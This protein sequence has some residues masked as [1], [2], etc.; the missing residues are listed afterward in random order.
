MAKKFEKF[1]FGCFLLWVKVVGGEMCG[2]LCH[3][4]GGWFVWLGFILMWR[5]SDLQKIEPLSMR[6]L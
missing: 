2:Y 3:V 5:L 6:R 4:V 1:K